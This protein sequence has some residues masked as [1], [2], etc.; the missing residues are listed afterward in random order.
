MP[1]QVNALNIRIQF[2]SGPGKA[3]SEVW[4]LSSEPGEFEV[5]EVGLDRDLYEFASA[6]GNGSTFM[7]SRTYVA[8]GWGASGLSVMEVV[9]TVARDVGVN[10]ASGVVL[11][12]LAALYKKITGQAP[13]VSPAKPAQRRAPASSKGRSKKRSPRMHK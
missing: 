4:E 5:D 7:F 12:A 6:T 1:T 10:V 11:A 8:G 2:K 13:S 9:L 3:P